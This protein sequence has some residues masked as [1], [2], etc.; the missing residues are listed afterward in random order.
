VAHLETTL[1]CE[2]IVYEV[3]FARRNVGGGMK[4]S[5]KARTSRRLIPLAIDDLV[6]S[7][8]AVTQNAI[9]DQLKNY[10]ELLEAESLESLISDNAIKIYLRDFNKKR[11][12]DSESL[13]DC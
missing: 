6:K 8:S 5:E 13:S 1:F 3:A 7:G 12:L 9:R 10:P 2:R 11:N 4:D